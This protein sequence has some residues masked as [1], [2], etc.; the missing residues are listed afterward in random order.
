ME[1]KGKSGLVQMESPSQMRENWTSSEDWG[2]SGFHSLCGDTLGRTDSKLA[3]LSVAF[4]GRQ[5]LRNLA[6]ATPEQCD[7]RFL[8]SACVSV[9]Y[10]K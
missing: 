10:A 8:T 4:E 7:L 3:D 5:T 2:A 9:Q 6:P 1:E